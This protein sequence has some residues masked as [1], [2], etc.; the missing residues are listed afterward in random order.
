MHSS[1][2]ART[3]IGPHRRDAQSR[4]AECSSRAVTLAGLALPMRPARRVASP[5]GARG[6]NE[7]R[8]IGAGE[9]RFR[10]RGVQALQLGAMARCIKG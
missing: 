9:K 2:T 5:S 6:H 8:E 3:V 4:R 10:P 1:S 7:Y